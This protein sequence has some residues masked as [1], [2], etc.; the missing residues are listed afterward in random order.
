MKTAPAQPAPAQPAPAQPV[1][2]LIVDDDDDVRSML[3]LI[4]EKE[5][6]TVMAAADGQTALRL[7]QSPLSVPDVVLLDVR[8]PGLSGLDVLAKIREMGNQLPVVLITAYADVRQSVQ[9]MKCGA[10]DY[11]TKPFDNREVA[12]VTL[13]ALSEKRVSRL[14]AAGCAP[15]EHLT[16]FT[17]MGA[18]DAVARITSDVH[19]VA[20]SDFSVLLIG[21]TGAGKDLVAEAIHRGSARREAPFVAVDCGAI[22]EALLESELFGHERGSFTG[23]DRQ[24]V[25]KFEEAHGGTLFLDELANLPF[26]SQAKL[27]RAI[28]RKSIYRVGGTKFID[29]NF[30]LIA[31]SNRSLRKMVAA[32]TFREDLYYRLCDF[33]IDIPALRERK[34]DVLYLA[35]VFLE[36]VEVELGKKTAGLSETAVE[37]L[38][39]YDWPGNVRE[40]KAVIRRAVLVAAGPITEKDLNIRRIAMPASADAAEDALAWQGGSLREIVQRSVVDVERKVLAGVLRVTGGNKAKAA[41]LLQVDYKTMHTKVKKFG[42]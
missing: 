7:L 2:A 10:Y 17:S 33:T 8:M 23:A 36:Q 15:L 32:G 26:G 34:M 9:A 29:V 19:R 30:R 3:T 37:A 11:L 18:S 13:Q 25:G 4:L 1:R 40:L 28:Q 41:R 5:G 6:L 12:R 27:L 24:K 21:E 22:P 20:T 14:N 38:V 16:L 35:K 31:A 42:I 39:A